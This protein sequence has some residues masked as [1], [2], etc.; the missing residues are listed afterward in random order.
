MKSSNEIIEVLNDLIK[1]NNDRIEGYE[2]AIENAAQI[3][4]KGLQTVFSKMKSESIRFTAELH[5]RV[6][7]LGGEPQDGTTV[8]GKLHR[9]WMDVK[10]TFTG[11]DRTSL[12][13]ACEFGEDAAQKAYNAALETEGLPEDIR[14][15]IAKQKQELRT[16]HDEIKAMRDRQKA[17]S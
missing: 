8:S 1:I 3:I 10:A 9:A 11:K 15:L 2:K 4:D 17:I 16:S 6:L 5:N 14:D 12:L 7:Q 13:E